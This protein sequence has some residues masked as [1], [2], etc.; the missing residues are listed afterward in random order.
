MRR[1]PPFL[2]I[3]AVLLPLDQ[4]TKRWVMAKLALHQSIPV[5]GDLFRIT[6]VLNL[7]LIHI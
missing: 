2:L 1:Y 3:L 7:S 5:L 4:L 6:Y